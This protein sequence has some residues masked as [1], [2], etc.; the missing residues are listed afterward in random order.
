M[1][2]AQKIRAPCTA[3]PV[4]RLLRKGTSCHTMSQKDQ[5]FQGKFSFGILRLKFQNKLKQKTYFVQKTKGV[6][7]SQPPEKC[8]N[9]I[10]DSDTCKQY[11]DF[12][13]WVGR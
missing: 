8:T 2:S 9:I 4:H 6:F 3:L 1:Q 12:N 5:K 13:T 11:R 7:R 10:A